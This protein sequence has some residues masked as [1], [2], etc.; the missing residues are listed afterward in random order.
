MTKLVIASLCAAAVTAATP[1]RAAAVPTQVS[2]AGRLADAEGPVDRAVDLD[3]RLYDGVTL[4]WEESHPDVEAVDGLAFVAL[5][6]ESALDD[7]VFT[8]AALELEVTVDGAT[9]S[10]RLPIAATLRREVVS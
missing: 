4:V 7:S 1:G 8:G 5:G 6:S 9:M 3:F 2:F 10:P